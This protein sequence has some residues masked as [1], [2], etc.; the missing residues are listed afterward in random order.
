MNRN[1]KRHY[2]LREREGLYFVGSSVNTERRVSKIGQ[3]A[4]FGGVRVT[5][6]FGQQIVQSV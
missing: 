4:G 1:K 5:Y 2:Y 3:R 6:I